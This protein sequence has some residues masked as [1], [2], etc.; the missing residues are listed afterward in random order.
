MRVIINQL[1]ALG[2]KTGIGHYTAELLH[3]LRQQS[4]SDVFDGYP[5]QWI[6]PGVKVARWFGGENEERPSLRSR[7]WRWVRRCGRVLLRRHQRATLTP[8]CYDLYHE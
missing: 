1:P 6:K 4:R 7:V 8:S 2:R 5:N 3:A